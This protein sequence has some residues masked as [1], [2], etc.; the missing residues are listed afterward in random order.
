MHLLSPTLLIHFR[1]LQL[2]GLP[3]GFLLPSL[4]LPHLIHTLPSEWTQRCPCS[5]C[6][7][8]PN[9]PARP[10]SPSLRLTDSSYMLELFW[11]NLWGPLSAFPWFAFCWNNSLLC[12]KAA[13]VAGP[14]R[15]AIAW[16][17]GILL[18]P[19][20]RWSFI[21][22]TRGSSLC[23]GISPWVT[24]GKSPNL[25]DPQF[26]V[27]EMG[28][29]KVTTLQG[30]CPENWLRRWLLNTKRPK[31]FT[32]LS[33]NN[34][35]SIYAINLPNALFASWSFFILEVF[36]FVNFYTFH[37]NFHFSQYLLCSARGTG[38]GKKIKEI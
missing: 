22:I 14:P 3:L 29:I 8:P 19:L 36:S 25:T 11:D 5:Q 17:E 9:T 7:H 16:A 20:L 6:Q 30:D 35:R 34:I 28:A 10:L 37:F 4:A 26:F 21:L 1:S 15:G 2:S 27:S 32:I 13:C 23:Y 33:F 18:K 24:S 31:A 12:C 38:K